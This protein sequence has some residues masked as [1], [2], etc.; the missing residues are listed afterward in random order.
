MVVSAALRW[1][2]GDGPLVRGQYPAA[3]A[4][5]CRLLQNCHVV[6]LLR[7]VLLLF[8]RV[9]GSLPDGS[10]GAMAEVSSCRSYDPQHAPG[11]IALPGSGRNLAAV[12]G[13]AL[14][15]CGHGPLGPRTTDWFAFRRTQRPAHSPICVRGFFYRRSNTRRS[16]VDL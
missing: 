8:C 13:L 5:V 16:V 12:S 15:G 14:A 9:S 3:P 7:F 4:G 1:F 6:V 2:P 11:G 10:H